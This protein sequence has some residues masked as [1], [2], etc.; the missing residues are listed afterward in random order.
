MFIELSVG[1]SSFKQ[2]KDS[3]KTSKINLLLQFDTNE[4]HYRFDNFHFWQCLRKANYHYI[5][6]NTLNSPFSIFNIGF[7][8]KCL[9]AGDP[10]LS[11]FNTSCHLPEKIYVD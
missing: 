5:A 4:N 9:I 8:C 11:G 1:S 10:S 6:A 7:T 3:Y 2:L